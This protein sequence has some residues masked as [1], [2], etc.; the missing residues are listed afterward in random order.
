MVVGVFGSHL[1]PAAVWSVAML[2]SVYTNKRSG[3]QLILQPACDWPISET[4]KLI[5]KPFIT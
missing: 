1:P 4:K 3:A 2:L 5:V